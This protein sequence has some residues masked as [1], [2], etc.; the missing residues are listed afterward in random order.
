MSVKP[1]TAAVIGIGWWSDVLADAA[2]RGS[3]VA[4]VSCFTRSEE[5]RRSFAAKYSCKA[6]ASYEEILKDPAIE[7]IINTT[8]N[9]VRR[10][11]YRSFMFRAQRQGGE[12]APASRDFVQGRPYTLISTLA[13]GVP[14]AAGPAETSTM[15]ARKV[16]SPST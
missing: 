9:G 15:A 4:I 8:P 11:H 3:S 7:A 16:R 13:A 6:A 2:R 5:K 14:P 12:T 1:V 10:L